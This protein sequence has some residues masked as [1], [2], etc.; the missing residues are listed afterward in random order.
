MTGPEKTPADG[1]SA[2][3]PAA[4]QQ[5]ERP[6]VS[7]AP[8]RS[9]P[10]SRIPAHLGRARTSTV[11][12]GLLFVAIFALYLTIKPA[13]PGTA[14]TPTTETGTEQPAP[15]TEPAPTTTAPG[16]PAEP[17]T[18]APETSSPTA[19]P[20]PT[21]DEPTTGTT[22]PEETAAPTVPTVPAPTTRA[23]TPTAASPTG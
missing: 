6:S 2:D 16:T 4:D 23:G 9:G 7:T 1:A 20:E 5:M 12:L 10:F 13:D 21:T 17:T 8:A 18:P 22:L 3:T 19:V 15:A 11:V 14:S